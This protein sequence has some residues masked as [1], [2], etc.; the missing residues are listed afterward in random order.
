MNTKTYNGFKIDN[1][2][3]ISPSAVA[4][5]GDFEKNY[6]EIREKEK[7][8]L[9]IEEIRKLP[10]IASNSAD[11]DLWRTRRNNINRF[12][13]YL[14]KKNKQLKILDV[15][16]GNG[17]FANLM[18]KQGHYLMGLDV[19]IVELNQAVE[20]FG[21]SNITWVY[22]D[23][24]SD[25]LPE[26]KFDIITFCGSFQYFE[27]PKK[28]LSLCKELLHVG[29]EIH[30]ID[31]PFYHETEIEAAKQRSKEYFHTMETDAMNKY[32]HH[33]SF[34]IFEDY[35]IALKYKP[36]MFLTKIFKDSP[37]PWIMVL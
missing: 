28:L 7:R 24:L 6:L 11:Y 35:H 26:N 21:A 1:G 19:N 4:N 12:L 17:F 14:E 13:K 23:I 29:G 16:C 22:A 8:I 34:N 2:V 15:G 36:N 31:S 20:A 27:N 33:N 37:F 30:I 32:F 3:H 9:S 18:Q 5:F 25:N 10:F